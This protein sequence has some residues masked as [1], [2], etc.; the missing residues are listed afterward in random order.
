MDDPHYSFAWQL[1]NQLG[2]M[3]HRLQENMGE[4][5]ARRTSH[6]AARDSVPLE[7]LRLVACPR[8]S[9]RHP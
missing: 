5:T 4:E 9:E 6:S 1:L 2:R 3:P 7:L 8:R